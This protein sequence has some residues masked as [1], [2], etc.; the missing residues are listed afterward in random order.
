MFE[1]PDWQH[2][3][4][5]HYRIALST[6]VHCLLQPFLHPFI[7]FYVSALLLTKSIFVC[8]YLTMAVRSNTRV[9]LIHLPHQSGFAQGHRNSRREIWWDSFQ[10]LDHISTRWARYVWNC[11]IVQKG[12][13]TPPSGLRLHPLMDIWCS[14]TSVWLNSLSAGC[15]CPRASEGGLLSPPWVF[16]IFDMSYWVYG[17]DS[18]PYGF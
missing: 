7:L 6:P 4:L 11:Q 17:Y 10:G 16:V 5:V 13:L 2:A 15:A 18:K 3:W 14:G 9:T 12:R 1:F 8:A